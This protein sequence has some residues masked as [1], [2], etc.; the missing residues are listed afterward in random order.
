MQEES[1]GTAKSPE[2][3]SGLWP[4]R[5]ANSLLCPGLSRLN[6]GE[7]V[8]HLFNFSGVS[9]KKLNVARILLLQN[10]LDKRCLGAGALGLN[11]VDL[12]SF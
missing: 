2:A 3:Y 4:C 6:P 12:L 1:T 5:R 7:L 9:V 8:A 11:V 10:R